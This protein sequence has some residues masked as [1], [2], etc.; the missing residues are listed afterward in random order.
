MIIRSGLDSP[1]SSEYKELEPSQMGGRCSVQGR[2]SL[3]YSRSACSDEI[4]FP[5]LNKIPNFLEADLPIG[6]MWVFQDTVFAQASREMN[7][8]MFEHVL[9]EGVWQC[10]LKFKREC[11]N[12]YTILRVGIVAIFALIQADG[13]WQWL[14]QEEGVW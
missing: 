8:I 12:V 14:H 11:S 9:Q 3:L 10:L 13:E 5:H 7:V 6:V 4:Y 2:I 1:L